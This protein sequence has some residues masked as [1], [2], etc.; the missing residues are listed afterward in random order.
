MIKMDMDN[1]AVKNVGGYAFDEANLH[2]TTFI[3]F[4]LRHSRAIQGLLGIRALKGCS[5][6]GGP[7]T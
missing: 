7:D 4:N 2:L 6:I 5:H 1:G 3:T